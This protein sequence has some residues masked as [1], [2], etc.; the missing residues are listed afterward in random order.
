MAETI[1]LM[2]DLSKAMN[3]NSS[4]SGQ[5]LEENWSRYSDQPYDRDGFITR[6]ELASLIDKELKIFE[7]VSIDM[8]GEVTG[9]SSEE[10]DQD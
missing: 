7:Q 3:Q 10:F 6:R 4:Y 8:N 9:T 1:V 2:K 5:G